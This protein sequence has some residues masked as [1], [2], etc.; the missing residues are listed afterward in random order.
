MYDLSSTSD[1]ED[2][3][4]SV[5]GKCMRKL[6]LLMMRKPYLSMD[7]D[8]EKALSFASCLCGMAKK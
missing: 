1:D 6:F 2:I 4:F 7:K 5:D 3:C 8:F